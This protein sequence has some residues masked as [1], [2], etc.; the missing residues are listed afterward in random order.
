MRLSELDWGILVLWGA[1]A[2][3]GDQVEYHGV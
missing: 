2:A 3:V 1:T